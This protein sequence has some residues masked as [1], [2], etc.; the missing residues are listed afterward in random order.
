VQY[1]PRQVVLVFLKSEKTLSLFAAGAAGQP[2]AVK[3]Y[4]VLAASGKPGPKLRDGDRQVPEG[5]YRIESLNPN[6]AYHLSLRLNYPN[7]DDLRY[8]RLDRRTNLGGDIMIHGKRASIG[9]LA[10]G[11]ESIEE[12]FTLAADTR[13]RA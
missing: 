5:I 6:S 3:T 2:K 12:I 11:D 7:E 4:P 13:Y 10:I 8:A 1:P 9:C